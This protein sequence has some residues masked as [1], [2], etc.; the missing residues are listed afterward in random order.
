MSS[1][2]RAHRRGRP[3]VA[4]DRVSRS[5]VAAGPMRRAVE[6][7][8]PMAIDDRPTATAIVNMNSRPTHLV[9]TPGPRPARVTSS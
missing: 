7:I 6:R 9:R 1:R 2:R 8:E 4:S 3:S 5:A